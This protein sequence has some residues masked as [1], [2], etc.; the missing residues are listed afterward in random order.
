MAAYILKIHRVQSGVQD[1]VGSVPKAVTTAAQ[2]NSALA[3]NPD[4]IEVAMG[5][6]TEAQLRGLLQ[7]AKAVDNGSDTSSIETA[8]AAVIP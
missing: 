3:R 1:A 7:Y 8:I 6:A 5:V 2:V 4:V